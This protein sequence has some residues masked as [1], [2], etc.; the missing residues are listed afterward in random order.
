MGA[1]RNLIAVLLVTAGATLLGLALVDWIHYF[2]T[3]TYHA[4]DR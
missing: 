3:L 4:R 1:R 2:D